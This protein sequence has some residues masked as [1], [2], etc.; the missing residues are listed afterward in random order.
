MN[1]PSY[2]ESFG[3]HSSVNY[4]KA[5]ANLKAKGKLSA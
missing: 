1:A 4:F 2:R 5:I 3:V